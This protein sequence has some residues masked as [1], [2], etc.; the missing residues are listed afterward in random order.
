[1]HICGHICESVICG[2]LL[3]GAY[4]GVLAGDV[5]GYM[6]LGFGVGGGV[7]RVPHRSPSWG[8]PLRLFLTTED[9]HGNL[10]SS[11][12]FFALHTSVDLHV[13][14]CAVDDYTL[15][16]SVIGWVECS[17]SVVIVPQ[18]VAILLLFGIAAWAR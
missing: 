11:L 9:Y 3:C 4:A 13:L 12:H 8:D 2:R 17:V 15:R 10:Q 6:R 16:L 14:E 5:R 7:T 18:L 1:M